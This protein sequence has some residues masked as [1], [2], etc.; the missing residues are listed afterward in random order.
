MIYDPEH[1]M[2]KE[3]D[4]F[5]N[6]VF[7]DPDTKEYALKVF[8]EMLEPI[9]HR[10]NM[11]Y[12]WIGAPCTGRLDLLE[13]LEGACGNYIARVDKEILT[14]GGYFRKEYYEQAANRQMLVLHDINDIQIRLENVKKLLRL[15]H[16]EHQ[17]TPPSNTLPEC[18]DLHIICNSV[19]KFEFGDNS[20]VEERVRILYFPQI[21]AH[22]VNC[23]WA[24]YFWRRLVHIY[25]EGIGAKLVTP[26]SVLALGEH[27]YPMKNSFERFIDEKLCESLTDCDTTMDMILKEYRAWMELQPNPGRRLKKDE[28]YDALL[29]KFTL[30]IEGG[31]FKN[32]LIT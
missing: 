16:N 21:Y 32:L 12:I 3:I 4:D 29:S 7:P 18:G 8:A 23:M 26:D 9:N 28:M 31:V 13:L 22:R 11:I 27:Y 30:K 20:I 14:S 2:Q 19:P 6:K 24:P 5:L 17:H 25:S 10:E 15:Q 1:P